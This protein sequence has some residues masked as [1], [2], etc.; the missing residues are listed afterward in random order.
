MAKDSQ[1]PVEDLYS[2][3]LGI[4]DGP[5]PP[6]H[7]TLLGLRRFEADIK[8]IES[9]AFERIKKVRPLCRVYPTEGTQLLNEVTQAKLCLTDD[10]SRSA[11]DET[12]R[13][14]SSTE[15]SEP[16]EVESD[17]Y[18]LVIDTSEEVPADSAPE[19]LAM[20][21][22]DANRT[23]GETNKS[24]DDAIAAVE[25][26]S[27]HSKEAFLRLQETYRVGGTL[28]LFGGLIGVFVLFLF[29]SWPDWSAE[30][31]EASAMKGTLL[32][33]STLSLSTLLSLRTQ[34]RSLPRS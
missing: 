14:P 8:R 30:T 2:E 19:E 27:R 9:A 15:I 11:Y 32:S 20:S 18:G 23:Q 4:A 12:L 29:L 6:D 25:E 24:G 17:T 26:F 10:A 21:P 3:W 7:Y 13:V 28:L 5:R 22:L 1:D 16:G 31:D 34:C 33:Q